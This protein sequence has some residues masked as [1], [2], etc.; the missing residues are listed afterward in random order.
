M[1]F[2]LKPVAAYLNNVDRRR[3]RNKGGG[4]AASLPAGA[5]AVWHMDQYATTP[6]AKVKNSQA[7][8]VPTNILMA[9]RRLFNNVA[10]NF[11]TPRTSFADSGQ[12]GPDGTNDASVLTGVGN[13][14]AGPN[15]NVT[16][17]AG[18]WTIACRAKRNGGSDQ[19]FKMSF[20]TSPIDTSATKTAT[21]SWQWFTHV[22]TRSAGSQTIRHMISADGVT[23]ADVQTMDWML[24]PGSVTADADL[25]AACLASLQG[26]MY[27]LNATYA[28]GEVDLSA[29]GRVGLAQFAQT[30]TLTTFTAMALVSKTAAGSTFQSFLCKP[31][32]YTQFAA[33]LQ[34][35][36]ATQGYF[37]TTSLGTSKRQVNLQDQ[38]YHL[39]TFRYDDSVLSYFIDDCKIDSKTVSTGDATIQD[40]LSGLLTAGSLFLGGKLAGSMALYDRAL[41]D[42]EVRT[43]YAAQKARAALS[44]ITVNR[45]RFLLA[46]GDSITESSFGYFYKFLPNASPVVQG[47]NEAVSG[48]GLAE[49]VGRASAIDA[50]LPPNTELGKFV[51]SVFVGANLPGGSDINQFLADYAAY[52]DARRAA[53]WGLA[54]ATI[55]PR[56]SD[57]SDSFNTRRNIINP[58][59]RTWVG[60]HCDAIIDFAADPTM[61][62]DSVANGTGTYNP[63]YY[64]DGVHPTDAGQVILETIYR[65]VINGLLV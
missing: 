10:L 20:A 15:S 9:Q 33:M 17:T 14:S 25:E 29:A 58:V 6:R 3:A 2:P 53:G 41:T 46:D 56:I 59:L 61:G 30:K 50:R 18:Q 51:L 55:L 16:L 40:L 4:G 65:P 62:P 11:W 28:N 1:A 5:I 42:D 8:G 19:S 45:A 22:G 12:A 39:L 24:L 38:G 44:G 7:S 47:R 43:A 37:G 34:E 54:V 49:V 60:L 36:G 57:V 23:G 63:T 26:D 32:S 35:S 13:F 21:A 27:F 48:S 52:C 64:S 31:Q